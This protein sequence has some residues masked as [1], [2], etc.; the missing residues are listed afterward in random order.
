MKSSRQR[1]AHAHV[2]GICLLLVLLVFVS[3][4]ARGQF[5][6]PDSGA[7]YGDLRYY[8]P[9]YPNSNNSGYRTDDPPGFTRAQTALSKVV[10]DHVVAPG[11][12]AYDNNHQCISDSKV[13][14][15]VSMAANALMQS[16]KYALV[17]ELI[18]VINTYHD[19]LRNQGG[20]IGE[21]L[22]NIYQDGDSQCK[23]LMAVIPAGSVIVSYQYEA[24]DGFGQGPCPEDGNG[25]PICV[26]GYSKFAGPPEVTSAGNSLIVTGLF[27]NW[28]G[29]RE[30]GA[31]MTIYYMPPK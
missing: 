19:P 15:V 21:F 20:A 10:V 4:P 11:K 8:N 7:A 27:M 17:G 26:I 28:S 12:Y 9:T 14:Q 18:S 6:G 1:T 23:P 31:T 29:N 16:K 2:G 30:R 5:F 24:R 13:G 25:W 22:A 3:S